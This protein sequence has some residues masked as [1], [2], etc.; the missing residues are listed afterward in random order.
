MPVEEYKY[1]ISSL[2]ND[3]P[4]ILGGEE[5]AEGSVAFSTKDRRAKTRYDLE[6]M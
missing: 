5:A 4:G 6:V 3:Q 1:R 2:N